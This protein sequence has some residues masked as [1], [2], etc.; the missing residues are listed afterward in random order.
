MQI[1]CTRGVP[2]N[3]VECQDKAQMFRAC[4]SMASTFGRTNRKALEAYLKR[5]KIKQ[6]DA[7]FTLSFPDLEIED[8]KMEKAERE[9]A[10]PQT[11][12]Q[13]GSGKKPNAGQLQCPTCKY[14]GDED[15]FEGGD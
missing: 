9:K 7:Q 11:G 4:L 14:I 10:A 15:E 1:D 2:V 5:A 13:D 6:E 12:A 3:F 8:L